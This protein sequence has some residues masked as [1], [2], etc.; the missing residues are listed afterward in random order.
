MKRDF[1][2]LLEKDIHEKH[3]SKHKFYQL[4]NE[5]EIS[6]EALRGY[7]QQYYKFVSEFPRLVSRVHSNT[8]DEEDRMLILDNLNEEEDK[9]L[10]HTELWLRFAE[11]IGVKRNKI[12]VKMLPETKG[13]LDS[14]RKLSSKSF[15]EGAA[16]LLA[17]EA[18]VPDIAALKM[19][20][21]KKH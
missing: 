5:G 18:Q 1:V 21:L 8:P 9:D 10:P 20:G 4:W 14:L 3:L 12:D 16:A 6:L 2:Q 17:Y 19:Q 13:M 15:L 11:G 7:A